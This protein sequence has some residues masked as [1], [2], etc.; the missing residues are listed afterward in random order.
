MSIYIHGGNWWDKKYH[1]RSCWTL[2]LSKL[3]LTL[4]NKSK[5][6]WLMMKNSCLGQVS[7]HQKTM[8]PKGARQKL[9]FE[10]K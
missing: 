6:P 3:I 1:E 2:S 5:E 8:T 4:E 7:K 10:T 9:G